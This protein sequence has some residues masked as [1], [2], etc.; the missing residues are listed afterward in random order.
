MGTQ[1]LANSI[2]GVP[3]TDNLGIAAITGAVSGA[4]AASGVGAVGQGLVGAA[5]NI[6]SYVATTPKEEINTVECAIEATIGFVSGKN[7]GA[8]LTAT[9]E[10]ASQ[11]SI[12][13]KN[14]HAANTNWRAARTINVCMKRISGEIQKRINRAINGGFLSAIRQGV[15]SRLWQLF[16]R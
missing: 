13:N 5:T 8:G 15:T 3:L 9:K 10:V 2:A 6:A 12:I 16:G 4:F 14:M 1:I 7:S 11:V